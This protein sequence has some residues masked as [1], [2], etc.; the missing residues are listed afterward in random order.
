MA[1][2]VTRRGFVKAG[3]VALFA[4]IAGCSGDSDDGSPSP[5]TD[6]DRLATTRTAVETTETT[7]PDTTTAAART[8]ELPFA[9][10]PPSECAVSAPPRPTPI[11]E[12]RPR[13][14][15]AYPGNLTRSTGEAFASEFERAYAHNE[16]ITAEADEETKHLSVDTGV[17]D[18]LTED[19]NG[20]ILVGVEGELSV[21]HDG[22]EDNPVVGVYYLA[23]DVAL[24]VEISEPTLYGVEDL[25]SV[26]VE[27]T[28][29]VHCGT[30]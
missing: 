16:F 9:V 21:M 25:H 2:P 10:P 13:E 14:Y 26:D 23:P 7:R 20:G 18:A 29:V 28:E 19:V 1:L 6:S 15:P 24:R 27:A 8:P 5:E 22:I 4:V 3:T 17:R 30:N 11:G 12:L